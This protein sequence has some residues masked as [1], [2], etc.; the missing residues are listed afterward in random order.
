MMPPEAHLP[1]EEPIKALGIFQVVWLAMA[2]FVVS[3]GYGALVP[4]FPAWL[5]QIMADSDAIEVAKHIGYLSAAYSAGVLIAAPLWGMVSDRLGPIRVLL[6]GLVGYVLSVIALLRPDFLGITGVYVM[7][8]TTGFFVAAVIPV[9]STI[10]ARYTPPITRSRHFAWLGAMSLLGFL[11]GPAFNL[12]LE[13]VNPWI[14]ARGLRP[15]PV[16]NTVILASALLGAIIMVG[17]AATL[18]H[19]APTEKLNE[20]VPSILAE[21]SRPIILWLLNATVMF[22]LAG[23][24]LGLV[25]EADKN[26]SSQDISVMFAECS[27]VMLLIDALLFFTNLL[28]RV[29]PRRILLAALV[30][31]IAGLGLLAFDTSGEWRYVGVSLTSAGTGV[32]LPTISFLAAGISPSRLGTAMGGLAATS[33]LGQTFGSALAGWLFPVSAISSFAW[34]AAPLVIISGWLS[35]GLDSSLRFSLTEPAR[36]IDKSE[37]ESQP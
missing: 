30:V 4:L 16:I 5:K 10:V 13:R 33:G 24:E 27:L 19:D 15:W 28:D 6:A 3:A 7:R 21:P 1:A 11:F 9:V 36:I 20:P 31:A 37:D 2:V 29:S 34:L 23:F 18:P 35:L 25:L 32:A 26:W 8:W 12:F 22:V 17:V 14:F